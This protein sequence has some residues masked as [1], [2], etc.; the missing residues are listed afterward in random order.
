MADG[1]TPMA[2]QNWPLK[3]RLSKHLSSKGRHGFSLPALDV[4]E[5]EA[6]DPRLRASNSPSSPS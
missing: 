5:T 2:E 3:T 6:I 4:P 1:Q